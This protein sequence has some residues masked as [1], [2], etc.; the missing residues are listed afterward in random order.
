[1]R[2][3]QI[4][5]L[6]LLGGAVSFAL[7]ATALPFLAGAAPSGEPHGQDHASSVVDLLSM[8]HAALFL[9]LLPTALMLPRRLAAKGGTGIEQSLVMRWAMLEGPA[10]FGSVVVLLAGI[11]GRLPGEPILYLNLGST[12]VFALVALGDL[13]RLGRR[14]DGDVARSVEYR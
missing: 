14:T 2:S 1:M 13:L 9:A 5:G 4:I 8:V 3:I 12:A 10:L 11:E 6:A 7:V